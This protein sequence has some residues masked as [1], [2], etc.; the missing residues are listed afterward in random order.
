MTVREIA[1]RNGEIVPFDGQRI[2]RAISA[3]ATAVAAELTPLAITEL[4]RAVQEEIDQ[5]FVELFPNVENIQDIVEKHLMLAGQYEVAKA[6]ILYRAER[7]RERDERKSEIANLARHG[8]L[9]AVQARRTQGRLRRARSKRR[10][11]GPPKDWATASRRRADARHAR[12]PLGRNRD[13]PARTGHGARLDRLRRTRSQLQPARAPPAAIDLQGYLG[14]LR[15]HRSLRW[16]LP[17]SLPQR[18]RVRHRGRTVRRAPAA[19]RPRGPGERAPPGA[20]PRNSVPRRAYAR[21]PLSRAARR[22]A[23]RNAPGVLDAGRHGPRDRGTR[24]R[25]SARSSSTT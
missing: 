13:R 23:S 20:R 17:P 5:R 11:R 15:R 4:S 9:T 18:H 1:K 14:R 21:R 3:A 10:S 25:P 7:R 22:P 19:V 8:R 12:Q 24:G 16:D 6:Y 2:E